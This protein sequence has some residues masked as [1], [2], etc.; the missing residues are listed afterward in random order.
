MKGVSAVTTPTD[1]P[2]IAPRRSRL[3]VIPSTQLI[4]SVRIA[5]RI[6]QKLLYRFIYAGMLLTG[7]KLVWDALAL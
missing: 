4:R 1:E 6:D 7:L 3:A 2:T 5:R